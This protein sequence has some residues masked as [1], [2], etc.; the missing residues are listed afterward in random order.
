MKWMGW[1]W[2]DLRDCPAP[3]IEAIDAEMRAEDEANRRA[4]RRGSRG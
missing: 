4:N 3:L 1:S 2:A